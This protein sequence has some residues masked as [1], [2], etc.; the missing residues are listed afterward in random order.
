MNVSFS[1]KTVM[2]GVIVAYIYIIMNFFIMQIKYIRIL[3]VNN[4]GSRTMGRGKNTV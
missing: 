4:L 1:Q 2:M 3:Y